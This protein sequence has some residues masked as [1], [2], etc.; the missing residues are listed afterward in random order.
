MSLIDKY[1]AQLIEY[2]KTLDE[3]QLL[4]LLTFVK[5][6]F[7]IPDVPYCEPDQQ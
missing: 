3:E 5:K 7:P 2:I 4:Y 6:V 1:I